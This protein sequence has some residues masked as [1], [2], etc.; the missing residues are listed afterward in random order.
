MA[1]KSHTLRLPTGVDLY[2]CGFQKKLSINTIIIWSW[3]WLPHLSLRCLWQ[4]SKDTKAVRLQSPIGDP[5]DKQ[6]A[7]EFQWGLSLLLVLTFPEAH[8]LQLQQ[9]HRGEQTPPFYRQDWAR[10]GE[11]A[12]PQCREGVGFR[13]WQRRKQA[14]AWLWRRQLL[15]CLRSSAVSRETI[16]ALSPAPVKG[17]KKNSFSCPVVKDPDE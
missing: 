5:K 17:R 12:L 15:T 9:L 7:L 3:G 16:K 11:K 1:F 2:L 8:C 4:V 13:Q 6:K 10:G 14:G